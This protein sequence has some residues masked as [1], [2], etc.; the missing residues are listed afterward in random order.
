MKFVSLE[1]V[2]RHPDPHPPFLSIRYHS[3]PLFSPSYLCLLLLL[4]FQFYR[5]FLL[6]KTLCIFVSKKKHSVP[7]SF[8]PPS[9]FLSLS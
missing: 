6:Y 5:V 7:L 4:S 9:V 8:S 2:L 3:I 1:S